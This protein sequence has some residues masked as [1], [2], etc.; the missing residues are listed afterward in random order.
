MKRAAPVVAVFVAACLSACSGPPPEKENE[1]DPPIVITNNDVEPI[2]CSG[3]RAECGG[4]CV[5]TSI[6]DEN[7]GQ[8]G[9]QCA[10]G[11]VCSE[12]SCVAVPADCRGDEGCPP[13]YFCDAGTGFCRLGCESN[14]DCAGGGFCNLETNSCA[15][16]DAAQVV[17]GLT[18]TTEGP[19]ACGQGC[20]TCPTTANGEAFCDGGACGLRC[21][22]GARECGGSCVVCPTDGVAET[23]CED[24]ACVAAVCEPGR[25]LC[26]GVCAVC[27][28]VSP[29]TSLGCDG[30]AC[31]VADCNEGTRLC[32]GDCADCPTVDGATLQCRGAA[33]EATCPGAQ[34]E[35]GGRCVADDDPN[36]CGD[37]CV[38]CPTDA[39]GAAI[40]SNGTCGVR[41]DADYRFCDGACTQCPTAN[42]SSTQCS[43]SVCVAAICV[44]GATPCATGCCTPPT[45]G[46]IFDPS[47]SDPV[48]E[49]ALDAQGYPHVAAVGTGGAPYYV[50]WTGHQWKSTELTSLSSWLRRIAIAVDSSGRAHIAGFTSSGQV[51]VATDLEA[52]SVSVTTVYTDTTASRAVGLAIDPSDIV[53]VAWPR[54]TNGGERLLTHA[55]S[56]DGFQQQTTIETSDAL[57]DLV[58][59]HAFAGKLQVL[60][61]I[62]ALDGLYAA[63]RPISGGS[64][65]SRRNVPGGSFFGEHADF[66]IGPNGKG[67]AAWTD[68]GVGVAQY[69]GTLWGSREEGVGTGD[70]EVD[71]ALDSVGDVHIVAVA[72]TDVYH[73]FDGPQGWTSVSIATSGS[74]PEIEYDSGGA[75]HVVYFSVASGTL[76]YLRL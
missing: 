76:E 50:R 51:Q 25:E 27:P 63:E 68:F 60:Y 13:Q 71:V 42:V 75:A 69:S 39:N 1:P 7:C 10:D 38:Q 21:D 66:A 24:G 47:S 62:E 46:T 36:N 5:D 30:T 52:G 22:D 29:G 17:C 43:G 2:E 48:V 40:C 28:A 58:V 41:C 54:R 33:C 18:C 72:S 19:T 8:C 4:R 12:G 20:E 6:D 16:E 3:G 26:G 56:A 9:T 61:L 11:Q 59:L 35:C 55:S 49:M 73:T 64:W 37:S 70:S 67:F 32:D 44:S 23:T 53:H 31:V 57:Y 65:V 45:V 14:E 74:E 34:H 15:C